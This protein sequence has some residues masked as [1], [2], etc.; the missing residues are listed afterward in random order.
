MASERPAGRLTGLRH[1][2]LDSLLD[3]FL[4]LGTDERELRLDQ[5]GLRHPRITRWLRFLLD[6]AESESDLFETSLA[7]ASGQT[8]DR[9]ELERDRLEPGARLGPWQVDSM[10]GHGGMG[11]VYRGHRADGR[12]E[13][14]VAI[15]LMRRRHPDFAERLA[16]ETRLLARLDH[17]SVA[18]ILD[19]G[20]TGDDRYYMVMDWVSGANLDV[21]MKDRGLAPQQALDVFEQVAEAVAH[22]HQRL[23]V[24]GDIKPANIRIQADGRAVLLDFG[25]AR[26]IEDD[27]PDPD[28]PRAFTPAFAA[29]E[30]RAGQPATTQTDVWSL[31]ALL[32]WIARGG[33]A[34]APEQLVPTELG[35]DRLADLVAIVRKATAGEA[36]DRYSGVPA[37]LADLRR[38]RSQRPISARRIGAIRRLGLWARRHRTAALLGLLV[39]ISVVVGIASQAWQARI[40]AAERD[41]ARF[42]AERSALLR[43]QFTLLFREAAATAEPG[44]ELSARALLDSSALLAEDTLNA[45]PAALA[46]IKAMLGEIYLAMDDFA[47]AEPLL[48]SF[49]ESDSDAVSPLLRAMGYGD[50]AQLELRKGDSDQALDLVDTAIEIL[51]QRPADYA[52]RRADLMGIRGQA[53]RGLGRWDEAIATLREALASAQAH[54]ENSRLVARTANNLGATLFYSGRSAEA[55]PVMEYAVEKWRLLGLEDGSDSLTVMTNLASLLHQMGELD[56][57][58]PLYRELIERRQRRFGASGALGAAYLNYASLLS[59]RYRPEEAERHVQQGLDLIVRFEGETSVNHARALLVF[60]RVL[61]T[62]G[63]FDRAEEFLDRAVARFDELLGTDHLFSKVARMYRA[64]LSVAMEA[65]RGRGELQAVIDAL[66]ALRP[67]ADS[68]LA[69]AHCE[70]ARLEI[71]RGQPQA[72]LESAGR[73]REL[74]KTSFPADSWMLAEVDALEAA[75]SMLLGQHQ[76]REQLMA[77]RERL[78]QV[79][80]PGHPDLRWC[81]QMLNG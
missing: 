43:D 5:L 79:L 69:V 77:A 47:A 74:R 12:F 20:Q 71:M 21:A 22:A 44:E 64:R 61:T 39:V 45:D 16:Q 23:V 17:P 78:A 72:G 46:A 49:V 27:D 24:H 53:L 34:A 80:G 66:E 50:L 48:R 63:E 1:R 18:R 14:E 30:Q 3:E 81:D 73:C 9:L 41:V 38:L 29:P 59:I 70:M 60:G 65:E 76:A 52:E 37:L 33:V 68:Y 15:K 56:R 28:A 2:M 19:G 36:A 26:V 35:F 55:L 62:M 51:Q 6:A 75:A 13:R 7:R 42:E 10:A 57:A 58:E 54:R 4:D 11:V 31:G 40:V 8:L 67:G 25:I 32:A